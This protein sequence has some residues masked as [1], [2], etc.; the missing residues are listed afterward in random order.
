MRSVAGVP[1]AGEHAAAGA[2]V[3]RRGGNREVV[4]LP[5]GVE[6]RERGHALRRR[7]DEN[8]ERV[9]E[10]NAAVDAFVGA[11]ALRR[12]CE[13]AGENRDQPS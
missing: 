10:H 3:G 8:A 13:R 7:V 4:L 11:E 9:G 12:Q 2:K 6:P 1:V 5:P